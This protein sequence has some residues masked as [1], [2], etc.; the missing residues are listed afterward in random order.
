MLKGATM[1][2]VNNINPSLCLLN[3]ENKNKTSHNSETLNDQMKQPKTTTTN[4]IAC[5]I[6][7]KVQRSINRYKRQS[8]DITYD[9]SV[10]FD[11]VWLPINN[12]EE[13]GAYRSILK[14][15]HTQLSN[16]LTH[17]C[18]VFTMRFDLHFNPDDFDEAKVSDLLK[19]LKK[20]YRKTG[21]VMHAWAREIDSSDTP[22]YH[23]IIAFNGNKIQNPIKVF[24]SIVAIWSDKMQQ[25][26]PHLCEEGNH[27]ISNTHNNIFIDAFKRHSYLAKIKTKDRQPA[28]KRNYGTSQIKPA[29]RIRKIS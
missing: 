10:N 29:I 24:N 23:C 18:K 5:V 13:L 21:K 9:E 4:Q 20:E 17:Y 12:S 25:P 2:T 28:N 1:S 16:M 27:M 19:R 7:E 26:R 3:T 8:K 6:P 14:A 15:I 22:H 11:G